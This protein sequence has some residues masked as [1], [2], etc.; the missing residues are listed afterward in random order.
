MQDQKLRRGERVQWFMEIEI[1]A[2]DRKSGGVNLAI[3]APKET[4]RKCGSFSL[5]SFQLDA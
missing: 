3:I 2:E 5:H 4:K 1:L